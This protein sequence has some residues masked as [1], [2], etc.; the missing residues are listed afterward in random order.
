MK[1][2]LDLAALTIKKI[3]VHDIPK[4]LQNSKETEP[5]YSSAEGTLTDGL[6][7]FFKDKIIAALQS[8]RA[9][10]VDYDEST[11]APTAALVNDYLDTEKDFIEMSK[12]VAKHLFEIQGG[13]NSA[14]ILVIMHGILNKENVLMIMKLERDNGVQINVDEK[15]HTIDIK[16][17][18]DLMLTSR[19]K[20]FKIALLLT[21]D[22]AQY[23]GIV[24][25]YQIDLKV[26]NEI[27]T[28][29]INKFLGC[30][31]YRDPKATT[32]EFYR[33]TKAY[34]DTVD[35]EIKKAKY[36]QDLN[37]YL[38]MT[39]TRLS[40]RE[41]AD[42]YLSTTKHRSEYENFLKSKNF[43]MDSFIKDISL[44]NN[45]IERISMEFANGITILGSKGSFKNKVKLSEVENGQHKA[46]VVSKITK[47]Q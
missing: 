47:I 15:S 24:M 29:F 23:D 33:L 44:I 34:I 42:D 13:S 22:Q 46:E 26:K 2:T 20:I 7:I 45:K 37:S 1:K 43:K 6:R 28:F 14:G 39:K 4:H 30:R 17:V 19:T 32:Q 5:I 10:K 11:T 35:D 25:D 38:Q 31:P 3:I 36:L 8:D 9:I 18:H 40:G 21:R 41:F 27:T 16:E 12:K